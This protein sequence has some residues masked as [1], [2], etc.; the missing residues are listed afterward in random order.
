M[1]KKRLSRM[2]RW[3][4]DGQ[5]LAGPRDKL[6][7]QWSDILVGW[8][9]AS[10]LDRVV[11]L[12]LDSVHDRDG[13]RLPDKTILTV[14]NEYVW[15]FT[16]QKPEFMFG[17]SIHP[18]RKDALEALERVATRGACVV[19]WIPSG[20]H[21]EPDDPKCY[22][23]YEAL[24]HYD[25]PLLTHTGI[26]HS[27]GSRRSTSNHPQKLIP[28]LQAGVKVIAAHC[29]VHLFL[30]EP[31]YFR[32]WA[33]L[34][35]QYEN[36]FGDLGAFAIV[37]RARYVRKIFKD[38][39]LMRKVLYGSDFPTIPSPYWCWQLG[40]SKMKQM[41]LLTNPLE[42]NLQMMRALGMPDDVF[43]NAHNVLSL[44]TERSANEC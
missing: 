8:I 26:E 37:T 14:N 4:L 39:V 38:D 16:A 34:A 24:A 19:K 44:S 32:S 35:R 33:A 22:P 27:L 28:A 25:I 6:N 40:P 29:G 7:D 41:S 42:R 36:M 2:V 1:S 30:H 23:F 20:Q 12:A 18:Y 3:A 15:Q 43:E 5:S 17:A 13:R 31:S 11:L 10:T 9:R 21:I